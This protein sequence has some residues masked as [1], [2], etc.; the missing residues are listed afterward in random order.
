MRRSFAQSTLALLGV[1]LSVSCVTALAVGC[2]G[3]VDPLVCPTGECEDTGT[4][5]TG[6]PDTGTDSAFPDTAYPE[7]YPYPDTAPDTYPY[8]DTGSCGWG[9]CT[10]GE[11]CG[12]PCGSCTCYPDGTWACAS[13]P[14]C[15]DSGPPDTPD[16][17]PPGMPP[18]GSGCY[19]SSRCY[20]PSA[21][22]GF[23]EAD[24]VGGSWKV[25]ITSC[26]GCPASEPPSGTYCPSEG[27]SCKW[28]NF[29]GG[30]DYGSCLG[31]RWSITGSSCPPPPPPP[32][33]IDTPPYGSYCPSEGT[34]CST[35]N[36]CGTYDDSYCSGHSWIV[37]YG[38]CLPPP[39]PCPG[40]TPP[41]GSYCG[42]SEGASCSAP[43]TCGGTSYFYCSASTWHVKSS[44]IGSC[45]TYAPPSGT[46]CSA[47]SSTMCSYPSAGGCGQSCF[48]AKDFRWACYDLPCPPPPSFDGG[49][50]DV[51]TSFDTHF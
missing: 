31:G 29:C 47:P 15:Y 43:D 51:G 35:R 20:Y 12:I 37:K 6:T 26:G 28:P 48:C 18:G 24:C 23:D 40:Y 19:G 3:R 45:P 13:D 30:A 27:A 41:D 9:R 10:P 2:G 49:V 14:G 33:P 4:P 22:G 42:G 39:P 44:C 16:Y 46:G 21:C 17:C 8:P 5:D 38:T 1:T 7:T 50:V 32:C 34:Y 36:S 25:S 11:S